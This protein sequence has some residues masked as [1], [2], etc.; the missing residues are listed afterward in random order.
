MAS[1]Q[2]AMKEAGPYMGLGLQL[3][4]T[5]AVYV[6]GGWLMDRW[7]D[8]TPWL[9]VVGGLIG[10]VAFFIQLL[11]MTR[12]MSRKDKDRRQNNRES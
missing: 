8:T 3:A 4:G 2:E 1:W 6:L 5:M 11:R 12:E 9:T 7:L 10:M